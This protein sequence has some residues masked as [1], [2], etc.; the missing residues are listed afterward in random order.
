MIEAD[1][2]KNLYSKAKLAFNKCILNPDNGYLKDENNI[3]INDIILMEDFV[4]VKF[5]KYE[6]DTFVIEVKLQLISPDK[7]LIGKYFYYENETGAP[8]D[9]SLIFV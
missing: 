4:C 6:I 5:L 9:D 8:V 3:P 2:L 1:S 7:R